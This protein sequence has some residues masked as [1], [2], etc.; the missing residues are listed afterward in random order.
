[1]CQYFQLL[2]LLCV[3]VCL[4]D[5]VR[6]FL[7]GLLCSECGTAGGNRAAVFT[8]SGRRTKSILLS[9]GQRGGV[10]TTLWHMSQSG[11]QSQDSSH[12]ETHH[13]LTCSYVVVIHHL[14]QARGVFHLFTCYYYF[15]RPS[16]W[17]LCSGGGLKMRT[18][19]NRIPYST[20]PPLVAGIASCY[21]NSMVLTEDVS[22]LILQFMC[23]SGLEQAR[24]FSSS[25]Q[26]T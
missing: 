22:P 15:S 2:L 10:Q 3:C 20:S 18:S 16:P 5:S 11:S 21:L 8:L 1:M 4:N 9:Q 25:V 19:T 23:S 6:S 14:S 12:V 24:L 17:W 26:L 7:I 13:T